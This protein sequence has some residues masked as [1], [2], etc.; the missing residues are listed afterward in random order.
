MSQFRTVLRD[1]VDAVQ[2]AIVDARRAGDDYAA[3]LYHARL[4]DLLDVAAR[5]GVDTTGWV[6]SALVA[7]EATPADTPPAPSPVTTA[8]APAGAPT[9]AEQT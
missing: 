9:A 2:E 7:P 4:A 6:D 5:T 1:R 8:D 3:S